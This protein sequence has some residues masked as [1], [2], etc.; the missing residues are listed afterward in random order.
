MAKRASK[1]HGSTAQHSCTEGSEKPTPP[2]PSVLKESELTLAIASSKAKGKKKS[3]EEPMPSEPE[4]VFPLMKLPA[5]LVI[6]V[7]KFATYSPS[8]VAIRV[9][10]RRIR[11]P[12]ETRH[13]KAYNRFTCTST[14]SHTIL[15]IAHTCRS[16][17]HT[18][19]PLYYSRNKFVFLSK[20]TLHVFL[21]EVGP[22][23]TSMI[24]DIHICHLACHAD[25][26]LHLAPALE[27]QGLKVLRVDLEFGFCF[28]HWSHKLLGDFKDAVDADFVDLL[29]SLEV[30]EL[31]VNI[32]TPWPSLPEGMMKDA[33]RLGSELQ[34]AM[35]KLGSNA[36]VSV[37]EHEADEVELE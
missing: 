37:V 13:G 23:V 20:L 1:K 24:T 7:C 6:L 22:S 21:G 30:L 31:V 28:A 14:T 35:Q 2:K 33:E 29:K 16:L 3:I 9:I 26:P 8:S 4:Q 5:E 12:L 18:A 19:T 27:M 10:D 11:N 25:Q 36:T 32:E 17:Y 34:A 15:A